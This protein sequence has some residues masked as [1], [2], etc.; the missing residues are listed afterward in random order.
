MVNT[1]HTLIK[2]TFDPSNLKRLSEIIGHDMTEKL[3]QQFI[4]SVPQYLTDLQQIIVVNDIEKL[5]QKIHQF[6]GE[7]LQL[8]ATQLGFLCEQIEN[9][10]KQEQLANIPINLNKMKIEFSHLKVIL[11]LD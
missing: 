5:R 6:K 1:N 10:I 7:S 9:C 11:K 3:V 4:E 8:G 2:K